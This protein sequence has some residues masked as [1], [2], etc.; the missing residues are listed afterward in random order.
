MHPLNE[1][2]ASFIEHNRDP[3]LLLDLDG[4]IMLA[5]RAFSHMLGWQ[6]DELEGL[7]IFSCPS[8]P[9]H[10]VEQMQQYH[11]R[12]VHAPAAASDDEKKRSALETIRISN[13]G[14]AYHMMLSITPIFTDSQEQSNWAVHLR[15][16]T[17]QKELEKRLLRAEILVSAGKMAAGITHE[18][19]NPLTAVKGFLQLMQTEGTCKPEYLSLMSGE[20]DRIEAF[21]DE[22]SLLAAPTASPCVET[23][24][25]K[26]L[27]SII[28]LLDTQAIMSRV[29][30]QF[31]FEPVPSISCSQESIKKALFNILQNGIE[32]MPAGGLLSIHLKKLDNTICIEVIDEGVGIAEERLPKLGEPFYS[33]KEKGIGLG[34]MLTFKIMQQHSWAIGVKS[35][36]DHGTR[37]TISIPLDTQHEK[38]RLI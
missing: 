37:V 5:N 17:E 3:I 1:L 35:Q 11:D 14:K 19:R 8:I 22:I 36:L 10:L 21:V 30:I 16:I 27:Q 29:N 15:D 7:N 9:P 18:I 25:I 24:L 6:K 13:D 2:S 4:T 33:N 26:L 34:L 20:V 38:S 12:I 28:S 23:D 31:D 32:S